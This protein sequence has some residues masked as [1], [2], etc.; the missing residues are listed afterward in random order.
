MAQILLIGLGGTGSRIVNNVVADLQQSAK[1][2]KKNFSFDDGNMSFAVFDTNRNDIEY[3]DKSNTGITNI[4]ISSDKKIREYISNYKSE[5]V[6]DWMPISR[7]L[8][9]ETMI[10]GASQMRS[11]S[12]LALF[13]TL[14][15]STIDELKRVINTMVENKPIGQ[16]IRVMIVSSLAGGTGSGMF[17]QTALWI[18]QY[19]DAH[20]ADSTIRGVFVL[21]DVFISTV[22]DIAESND[23]KESLY[24][25]AYG[26][27]KELNALTKIKVKGMKPPKPVR[28]DGLFDSERNMTGNPIFDYAFLIDNITTSGNEMKSLEEYEKFISKVIYMQLYAPMKDNLYSEEDNLFKIFQR[29]DE[30]IYGSCGAARAL[31]PTE[32]VR[33][34]CAMRAALDSISSGWMK[35]DGQIERMEKKRNEREKAGYNPEPIDKKAEYIRIFDDESSKTGT[36]VGSNRLFTTIA[37]DVKYPIMQDV[38]D[39]TVTEWVNKADKFMESLDTLICETV[40]SDF[41]DDFR[42][43]NAKESL[44]DITSHADVLDVYIMTTNAVNEFI[45]KISRDIPKKADMLLER[46]FT[47]DMGDVNVRNEMSVYGFLTQRDENDNSRF[48]HPIAVRYLLYKLSLKMNEVKK[49]INVDGAKRDARQG[50]RGD[51]NPIDFDYKGTRSVEETPEDFAN[52]ELK[53]YN[54]EKKYLE[55]FR[56]KYEQFNR[57]QNELC[58]KYAIQLLTVNLFNLMAERM[59]ILIKEVESFFHELH[60]VIATLKDSIRTNIEATKKVS[61]RTIYIYA[62]ESNKEEIYQS[63]CGDNDENNRDIN[64]IVVKSLYGCFCAKINDTSEYNKEY[65]KNSVV[66]NFTVNVVKT[67]KKGLTNNHRS[68]IEL[69]LY[70]A[71]TRQVDAR[72]KEFAGNNDDGSDI[73]NVDLDNERVL[74]DNIMQEK[75][76]R[77]MSTLCDR[78]HYLAAP[79]IKYDAE[80]AAELDEH[81][82]SDLTEEEE[83][84]FDNSEP[85]IKNKT[86]WGFNP[87]LPRKYPELAQK[88]GIRVSQQQNEAYGIDELNCYRGIYGIM[89]KYIPKLVET[90]KSDFYINYL[91]TIRR[92]TIG[93]ANGKEG[94]LTETPHIDKTWHYILPYVTPEKQ[95][96]TE[97]EFYRSFWMALAY[98]YITL[99]PEGNFQTNVRKKTAT[100]GEYNDS[101]LVIYNGRTVDL[102]R[103]GDLIN[104]L[105]LD[106]R[107]ILD[108]QRT[109][110]AYLEMDRR[111]DRE[112]YDRLALISGTE[113]IYFS[114]GKK[115]RGNEGGLASKG[116]LNAVTIITKYIERSDRQMEVAAVL[117]D[118]LYSLIHEVLSDDFAENEEEELE[119]ECIRLCVEIY[120]NSDEPGKET[121]HGF[122]DWL[123]KVE[124]SGLK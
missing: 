124:K 39:D 94:A 9:E 21:P 19:L 25:N 106:P 118:T 60:K 109:L 84:E 4:R 107:F 49:N 65:S 86:F 82:D 88:L 34:Y 98:G 81:L 90:P 75:Y 30:P 36:M 52:V 67:F 76:K 116:F 27:I 58:R 45:D 43:M 41:C 6:T 29:C 113:R 115:I 13:D 22:R 74:S 73:L 47:A 83:R 117:I 17:I 62:S 46:I 50:Y 2:Q 48:V 92:M 14:N 69:D 37:N 56:D 99:N 101:E 85:K 104:A 8:L 91:A 35:I 78:L 59:G 40:D 54:N 102:K 20:N 28:L 18:R 15:S 108:T 64:N 5:G 7:K 72:E 123:T 93:V 11:K 63:I 38:G 55:Q 79:C 3:I 80:L 31:Y 95:M 97:R 66:E 12:R 57:T 119:K 70:T 112:Q 77:E 100:G 44:K 23:E 32:S 120:N 24:A 26:A 10:D 96:E 87:M 105:K 103:I 121:I 68:D 53:W 51:S 16:K 111:L 122:Q 61:E 114:D 71:L 1:R 89:A 42:S 110:N 33:Q